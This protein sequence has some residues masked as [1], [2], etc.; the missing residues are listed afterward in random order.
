M[1][2]YVETTLYNT[3]DLDHGEEIFLDPDKIAAYHREEFQKYVDGKDFD[4]TA[5]AKY[6]LSQAAMW[7]HIYEEVAAKNASRVQY[8]LS[9]EKQA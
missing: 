3:L 8:V 2:E 4:R 1:A 5:V 6:A 7:A 9:A